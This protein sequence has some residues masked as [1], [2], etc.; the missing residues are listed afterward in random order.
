MSVCLELWR[1]ILQSLVAQMAYWPMDGRLNGA[2]EVLLLKV[3]KPHISETWPSD[4][5]NTTL[6]MFGFKGFLTGNITPPMLNIKFPPWS[7]TV[8]CFKYTGFLKI[9]FFLDLIHTLNNFLPD[10]LKGNVKGIAF[11]LPSLRNLWPEGMEWDVGATEQYVGAKLTNDGTRN[12]VTG[13]ASILTAALL[14][15]IRGLSCLFG[16]RISMCF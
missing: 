11:F 7:V 12:I 14:C 5:N 3:E 6:R 8:V 1:Q 10:L 13:F 4:H 15:D 9:S 16:K 2:G